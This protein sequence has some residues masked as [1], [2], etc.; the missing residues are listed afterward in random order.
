MRVFIGF[1][2]TDHVG[3]DR[4]T[5]KVARWFEEA[6]PEGC[7]LR[8]VLRQQLLVHK[9]IP[10]TSHNS[11]ACLVLDVADDSQVDPLVERAISH[12]KRYALEG[13]DP[14]VCVAREGNGNLIRLI[15]FGR[16]CTENIVT[17]RDAME[18]ASDQHLSGH[19]GTNDGII[20]AAASVGLT[21]SGWCGRF[22]E[23]GR[24]R[25]IPHTI[26]VSELEQYNMRVVSVDRDARVPASHDLVYTKGWTRPRLWGGGAVL[27]VTPK[28]EGAW[29]SVGEKRK[30][31]GQNG[32]TPRVTT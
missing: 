26:R 32:G 2:D 10:Y 5:G 19:G 20:G 21:A 27:L 8:G 12:I 11:A 29:E 22:I 7:T 28:K 6:L 16:T 30:K 17:Q 23:F 1:D 4:G 31:A 13:S 15:D 3:A 24:L 18:A 14:G 25:N 9:D